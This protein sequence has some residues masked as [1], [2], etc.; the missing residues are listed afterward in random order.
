M[1]IMNIM[2]LSGVT[3]VS[4]HGAFQETWDGTHSGA[5]GLYGDPS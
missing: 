2:F 5:Y 4:G 1:L 3:Y